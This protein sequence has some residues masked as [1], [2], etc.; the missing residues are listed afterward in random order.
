MD[1]IVVVV[2]VVVVVVEAGS[3]ASWPVA[4]GNE[5]RPER[6]QST[7]RFCRGLIFLYSIV[8]FGPF[9]LQNL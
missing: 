7:A 1:I 4:Y 2:V 3:R 9:T 8:P 6:Y 5:A